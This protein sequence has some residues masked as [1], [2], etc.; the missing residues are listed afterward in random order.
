MVVLTWARVSHLCITITD[1]PREAV[2]R[3]R[4]TSAQFYGAQPMIFVLAAF[5]L[6]AKQHI[7]VGKAGASK[8]VETVRA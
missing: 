8:T 7:T 2:Q 1:Y 5:V 6:V 3:E 4:F